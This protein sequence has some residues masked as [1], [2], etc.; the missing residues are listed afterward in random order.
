MQ[1]K[2][3]QRGLL[4]LFISMLAGAA[5]GFVSVAGFSWIIMGEPPGDALLWGIFVGGGGG[6]L[7]GTIS[8]V[9]LVPLLANTQLRKSATLVYGSAL[10]CSAVPGLFHPVLGCIAAFGAHLVTGVCAHRSWR[11]RSPQDRGLSC[12]YC[13]YEIGTAKT[14]C[15]ECGK[16]NGESAAPRTAK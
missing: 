6:F 4:V 16:I 3:A 7:L 1:N 8:S 5:N 11:I 15:P 2:T 9:Y 13:S 12:F 10:A 14:R